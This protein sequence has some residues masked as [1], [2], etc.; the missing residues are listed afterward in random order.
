MRLLDL[1]LQWQYCCM[2]QCRA[3][4]VVYAYKMAAVLLAPVSINMT[5]MVHTKALFT[6]AVSKQFQSSFK[7]VSNQF[8]AA[9]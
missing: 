1:Y 9:V 5:I 6:L 8:R 3:P 4:S 7:A 2:F